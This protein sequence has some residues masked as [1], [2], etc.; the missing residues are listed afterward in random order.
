M[1]LLGSF[2][3]IPT[4]LL[5]AKSA[6]YGFDKNMLCYIYSY[7]ESRKQCVSVNKIK[8]TFKEIISGVPEGS[9][10]GHILCKISINDF[11]YFI[12]IA[13]THNF[14]DDNT[15]SGF[16]KT[17]GNIIS[18]VESESE[19]AIN[20]FKENHKIMNPGKFQATILDKRKRIHA[21]GTGRGGGGGGYH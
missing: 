18:I 19:I 8:I 13:S 17:I 21:K 16:A 12:L 10:V 2:D 14:A 11:F 7:F 15:L 6:A 5:V 4:D 1:D 9:F 20:W 3:F